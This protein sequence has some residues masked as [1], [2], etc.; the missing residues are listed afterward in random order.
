LAWVLR[1]RL[2]SGPALT[3]QRCR[4][5]LSSKNLN[6]VAIAA[7]GTGNVVP[8]GEGGGTSVAACAVTVASSQLKTT[9]RNVA[10]GFLMFATAIILRGYLCMR[11]SQPPLVA[12]I[13][14]SRSHSWRCSRCKS[15]ARSRYPARDD[16]MP[17]MGRRDSAR[18]GAHNGRRRISLPTRVGVQTRRVNALKRLTR[19]TAQAAG[20][21]VAILTRRFLLKRAIH[22]RVRRDSLGSRGVN[23]QLQLLAHGRPVHL[24]DCVPFG[25]KSFEHV[26]DSCKPP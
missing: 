21:H 7:G 3:A 6:I 10:P 11:T 2:Q 24:S 22:R 16:L 23:Y 20:L 13:C 26:V 17:V 9:W 4:R 15:C 19:L 1:A 14:S 25:F 18:L 5:C 8:V 12:N